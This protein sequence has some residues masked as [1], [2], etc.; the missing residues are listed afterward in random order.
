MK[1]LISRR[2]FLRK[3]GSFGLLGLGVSSLTACGSEESERADSKT[4]GGGEPS[5]AGDPCSDV[6]DL[7]E[8]EIE[9]RKGAGYVKQTSDPES[10]CDNCSFWLPP[11]DDEPC[12]GCVVIPGPIHPEG[13]CNSW[14]PMNEA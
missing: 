3:A 6:S 12:G 13:Y 10:R 1:E 11:K 9:K 8:S 2:R 4:S 14:A 5:T 7:T